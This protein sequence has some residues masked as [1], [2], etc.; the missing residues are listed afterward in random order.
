MLIELH[1]LG[2]KVK[3]LIEFAELKG[4]TRQTVY[5]N[6]IGEHPALDT[7]KIGN[8]WYIIMNDKAEKWSPKKQ[9]V[10]YSKRG[11]K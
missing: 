7:I 8:R 5:N 2:D 9:M 1:K 4:T 10:P 6:C 3:T 11:G